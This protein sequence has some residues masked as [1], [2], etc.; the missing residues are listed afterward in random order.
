MER[1]C[2]ARG[3]VVGSGVSGFLFLSVSMLFMVEF[4]LTLVTQTHFNASG[5]IV[6]KKEFGD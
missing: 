4:G 3:S 2:F 1:F 6:S 5:F